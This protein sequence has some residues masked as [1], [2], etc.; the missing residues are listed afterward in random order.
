MPTE[1]DTAAIAAI[2]PAQVAR[3]VL[4]NV[5]R[6]RVSTHELI[7]LCLAT[8]VA[9]EL[10]SE[11]QPEPTGEDDGEDESQETRR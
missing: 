7:A 8:L 9:E 2:D 11:P 4:G 1:I 3:R 5:A 10:A 6:A